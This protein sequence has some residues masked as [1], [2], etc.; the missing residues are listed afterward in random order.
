VWQIDRRRTTRG[1][2]SEQVNSNTPPVVTADPPR[3]TVSLATAATLN[4]APPTMACRG[5]AAAHRG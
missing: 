3:Q 4:I 1:G 5:A 2:N